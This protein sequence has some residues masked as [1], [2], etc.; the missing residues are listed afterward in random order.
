MNKKRIFTLLLLS[1]SLVTF[2][3]RTLWTIGTARTVPAV[4]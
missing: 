4:K 2:G 3:Q 1:V